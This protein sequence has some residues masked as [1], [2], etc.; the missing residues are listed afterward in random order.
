MLSDYIKAAMR[1]A[2][3]EILSDDGTYYGS[4]PGLDGVWANEATL[5]QCRDELESALGD[6]ILFSIYHHM[7]LPVLDGIELHIKEAV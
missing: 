5:E 6:W 3:Y 4:I 1:R 7:A 2:H